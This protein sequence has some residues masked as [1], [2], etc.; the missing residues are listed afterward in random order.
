MVYLQWTLVTW[1]CC[2]SSSTVRNRTTVRE[3]PIKKREREGVSWRFKSRHVRLIKSWSCAWEQRAHF[4]VAAISLTLSDRRVGTQRKQQVSSVR[5]DN[6]PSQMWPGFCPAVSTEQGQQQRGDLRSF[7]A[8]CKYCDNF[9]PVTASALRSPD[10]LLQML[11]IALRH[12]RRWG[13]LMT[14]GGLGEKWS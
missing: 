1:P 4:E 10:A 7:S 13:A 5:K 12:L 11:Q 9:L 6:Q 2:W 8:R 3:L 14:W